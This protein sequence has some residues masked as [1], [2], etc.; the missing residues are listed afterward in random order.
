MA[1]VS[2]REFAAKVGKEPEQLLKQL[3][4]AGVQKASVDEAVTSDEKLKLLDFL[5]HGSAE[6]GRAHV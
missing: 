2:V 3:Q 5:K 6:I 1:D 4:E